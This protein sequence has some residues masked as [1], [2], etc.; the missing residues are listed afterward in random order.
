MS[1]ADQI[2]YGVVMG[3]CFQLPLVSMD[4]IVGKTLLKNTLLTFLTPKLSYFVWP[5]SSLN[6]SV[7]ACQLMGFNQLKVPRKAT[8]W[9]ASGGHWAH[10]SVLFKTGVLCDLPA[11]R[12]TS[13]ILLLSFRVS[14]H[15]WSP[16]VKC[17]GC[18]YP[19]TWSYE[20]MIVSLM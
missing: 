15:G 1:G 4:V 5:I 2:S 11:G 12:N 19:L 7:V 14:P 3:H 13:G 18:L 16:L 17:H 8:L 6:Q 10:N 20:V 9:P